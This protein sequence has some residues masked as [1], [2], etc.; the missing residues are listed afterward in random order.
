MSLVCDSADDT[1]PQKDRENKIKK[2]RED[3]IYRKEQ[4][5]GVVIVEGL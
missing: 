5:I 3:D 4:D 1:R 2:S